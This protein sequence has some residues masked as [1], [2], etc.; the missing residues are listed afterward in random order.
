MNNLKKII[1]EKERW[2]S[3]YVKSSNIRPAETS[4]GRELD[5]IYTPDHLADRDYLEDI[6]FSGQFPFVRGVYPNMYRGK[7]WTMRQYAGFGTPEESNTRFRSL[8]KEG[9]SGLSVA[10]D[11]P[12]QIGFDSDDP[13]VEEE[14]GRVGVAVDTLKDM[15]II[16]E[17]IPLDKITTSFTINPTAA[18]IL[19]MYVALAQKK[20]FNLEKIG[21]TLQND[22]LKEYLARGTQIYPPSPS[23]RLIGDVIEYCN[24]DVPR[25]NTISICGY[26]MREAGCNLIQESA[27]CLLDAIVYVEEVLKRGINIDEFAPRL[28]FLLSCGMNLFEEVAKFRATRRLWA[29]IIKSRFQ[30]K[31][32][33]SMMLRMFSGCSASAFTDKEPLNNISRGTIMSLVAV[34]AGCQAI[35]TTAYDEAYSIPTEE[36][37]RTALRTQQVI[38]YE[39]DATAVVDPMGGSYFLEH[40]TNLIEREIEEE[41]ARIEANGGIMKGI[42]DGSIQREIAEQAYED[43]KKIQKKEKVIV[44]VN[45][46]VSDGEE[47]D[48]DIHQGNPDVRERQVM[49]LKEVKSNRDNKQV[50]LLLDE[51]RQVAATSRN[52]MGPIL[53]AVNEYA[54]IG[55]ISNSL[56][57]VFGEY[58]EIF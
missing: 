26:H 9:Q 8:L 3:R 45:K 32:P 22:I 17:G 49:R 51:I 18:V 5:V 55:E 41:M 24:S 30:A 35:H 44:G 2:Y 39:T 6:G 57:E 58:Q 13:R 53:A 27:Y 42:S 56:K 34:L 31:N 14:V 12:T 20:G 54:T 33:K 23:L 28:S 50:A 43:A 46:F 47:Y 16:F 15:E 36:S 7:L 29:K 4:W 21:G 37:T 48:M 52:L 19:A 40:L 10:F 1:D 11:L 38:A 25:M